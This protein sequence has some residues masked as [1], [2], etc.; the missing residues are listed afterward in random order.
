MV[1]M[2]A[3]GL[4]IVLSNRSGHRMFG[5]LRVVID[6]SMWSYT[7]PTYRKAPTYTKQHANSSTGLQHVLVCE[8]YML[9]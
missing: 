3:I 4:A 2:I 8:I 7:Q 1:T 9:E 5:V 6:A